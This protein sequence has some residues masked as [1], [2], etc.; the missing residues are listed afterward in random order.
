MYSGYVHVFIQYIE[1]LLHV[2]RQ[3]NQRSNSKKFIEL[4]WTSIPL[5]PAPSPRKEGVSRV[6]RA[7]KGPSLSPSLFTGEGFGVGDI[8]HNFF[9][10]HP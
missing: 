9:E 7:G 5:T 4:T 1:V 2:K 6:A 3:L 10:M 8:A